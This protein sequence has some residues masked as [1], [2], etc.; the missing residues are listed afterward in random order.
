MRV[1][2]TEPRSGAARSPSLLVHDA[3]TQNMLM[4]GMVAAGRAD[5]AEAEDK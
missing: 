5:Y 1:Q 4:M 3:I 2:A